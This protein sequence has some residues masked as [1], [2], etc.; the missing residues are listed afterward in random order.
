M[1]PQ[2]EPT[3][4]ILSG[5]HAGAT[6]AIRDGATR[7]GSGLEAEVILADD[8]V[9]GEHALLELLDGSL[10][11]TALADGVVLDGYAIAVGEALG[12]AFASEF[13]VAGVRILCDGPAVAMA[14]VEDTPPPKFHTPKW[15]IPAGI[16]AGVLVLVAGVGFA[17]SGTP[18][19]P[20]NMAAK[21]ANNSSARTPFDPAAVQRELDGQLA[22]AGLDGL[23]V[24]MN[25]TVATVSGRIPSDALPR[26]RAVEAWADARYGRSVMVV[27]AVATEAERPVAIALD[28]VWS[29]PQPNVVVRGERY[30]VG[31]SLPGGWQVESIDAHRILF[32]KNGQSHALSY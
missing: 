27:S 24:A 6:F 31:A 32:R 9:S 3:L 21:A 30:G 26:W 17:A 19:V 15:L 20:G 4:R 2:H 23:Q 8:G 22:G 5:L 29:G 14:L 13:E 7:I 28:A 25:G 12:V 1:T 18:P 10:R 11:L 16:A